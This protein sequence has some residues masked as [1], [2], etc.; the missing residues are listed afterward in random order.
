MKREAENLKIKIR[1]LIVFVL[2]GLTLAFSVSVIN[3]KLSGQITG[4]YQ[5]IQDKQDR[6][7]LGDFNKGRSSREMNLETFD[8]K[9]L[10]KTA[11]EEKDANIIIGKI[12]KKRTSPFGSNTGTTF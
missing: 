9:Y 2:A 10:E 3:L 7:F 4:F 6:A 5:E 12:F 11:K 8:I 1:F